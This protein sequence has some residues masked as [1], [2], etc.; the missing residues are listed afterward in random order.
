MSGQNDPA[1]FYGNPKTYEPA[2]SQREKNLENLVNVLTNLCKTQEIM[3]SDTRTRLAAIEESCRSFNNVRDDIK[4]ISL[5]MLNLFG[6]LELD[7]ADVQETVHALQ[8]KRQ[9]K[10]EADRE[11]RQNKKRKTKNKKRF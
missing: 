4:S 10:L 5:L 2:T 9:N 3:L 8:G 7:I 11:R 1:N 6:N